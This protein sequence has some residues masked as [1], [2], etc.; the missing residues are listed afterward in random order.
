MTSG[1]LVLLL[2]LSSACAHAQP[3]RP[4]LWKVSDADNHIY[5]LGSFHALKPED[6]PW[7]PSVDAAVGDAEK[8]VFELS[9]D[10]L[11][12]PAL[13]TKMAHAALI[14]KGMTLRDGLPTALM[15]EL[16][17]YLD[18]NGIPAQNI[19]GFEPWFV[20]LIISMTEMQ[21]IGY[22]PKLGMDQQLMERIA[23]S[24]KPA[25]GLETAEE[26]IAA[27][28]SMTASEQQLA[29]R[30]ALDE[31]ARFR[32]QMDALHAEWRA[33]DAD[34]LFA[35]MGAELKQRYPALYQRIDVER[36]LAWMPK[37]RSMLDD[38][39]HDDSL[40]V[41]GSLHL[42]GPDGLVAKLKSAGYRVE[43]ID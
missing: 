8:Y 10:E 43:R 13:A 23:A 9:P 29:L 41:V 19:I 26:Q 36:N 25:T 32:T 5:L 21:R 31:A 7:S 24:G 38:E 14:G 2:A 35:R 42:L 27:L 12:S 1:F 40:V 34:A 33:G 11:R 15:T 6:Y 3:P 22:D 37:L 17:T 39:R 4:L 16:Q 18:K 20:S 28:D 30:E